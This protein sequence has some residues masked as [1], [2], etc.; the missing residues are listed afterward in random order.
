MLHGFPDDPSQ[1]KCH[2]LLASGVMRQM[3]AMAP[4]IDV[5]DPQAFSRQVGT[6]HEPKKESA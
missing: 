3:D 2:S 1:G 6:K 5:R 4:F